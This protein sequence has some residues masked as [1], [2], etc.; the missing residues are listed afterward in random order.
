MKNLLVGFECS[1]RVRD[2]FTAVG[3]N[4]VSCDTKPTESPGQHIQARIEDVL[5]NPPMRVDM[6]IFHPPCTKLSSSGLHWNHRVPGRQQETEEAL[7]LVRM[8]FNCGIPRIAIENPVGCISTR[9]RPASQYIQPYQF[10]DDAS[11]RTGLWLVGLPLLV[12]DPTQ[13]FTGR[14]VRL[15]NGKMVERWSNQTD[16]GQ[17]RLGPSDH[18]A[19]DRAVTYLGIARAMAQQW[20]SL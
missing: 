11:K 2:A 16:S 20:G 19:A 17:N 6:G 15:Q 7:D 12:I 8:L 18:R 1:G 5:R 14:M 3:W 13:R 4:A 9:I 10:G